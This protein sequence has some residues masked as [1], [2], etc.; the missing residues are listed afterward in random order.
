MTLNCLL[1]IG[2]TMAI[3]KPFSKELYEKHDNP[4]KLS[5]VTL[6]EKS[7]HKVQEVK[8]N[9]YADVVSIKD[10]IIYHNEAE[11]KRAWTKEWP[12]E[13]AEIRIPE[14]KS[15]LLKKYAGKVNFYIFNNDL[16]QCWYIKGIQL[17]QESLSTA[18]G[19]NIMK[20][21]EFFHIPYTEAELICLT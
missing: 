12:T 17:T 13:W 14:R 7:G 15:R 5:L 10:G 6:L 3:R 11:V 1:N 8:E 2:A 9:F 16:S 18:S 20:G 21:E 4:A 19:R